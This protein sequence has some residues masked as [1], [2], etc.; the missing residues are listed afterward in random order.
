MGLFDFFKKKRTETPVTIQKFDKVCP[1]CGAGMMS[2]EQ[3]CKT[4]KK[5]V[6]DE[7]V[8]SASKVGVDTDCGRAGAKAIYSVPT[9][10]VTKKGSYVR[11]GLRYTTVEHRDS[12][13]GCWTA[14][15]VEYN[16][17]NAFYAFLNKYTSISKPEFMRECDYPHMM[18]RGVGVNEV[19]KLHEELSRRGFYVDAPAS[20]T[21]STYKVG[22]IK[23]VAS[24]LNL[25]VKGK[26]EQLIEQIVTQ[27]NEYELK[28]ILGSKVQTIS[29]YGYQWMK[30]HKEEY[31]YYNS[32]REWKSFEAYKAF[33]ETHDP[34][35]KGIKDCMDKI[36][37]DK[38]QYGRYTYDSLI[39]YYEKQG[40]KE[41][42]ILICYLKELMLDMSGALDY[43]NWKFC[44][45]EADMIPH[46]V[47]TPF[48][49]RT[50]PGYIDYY[51]PSMI[52]E[53]YELN[54]PIKLCTKEMFKD[55]AEMAIEGTL[56][57]DTEKQ[58]QE[59]LKK[60]ALA[61]ASTKRKGSR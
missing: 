20:Q 40:G 58:Y 18:F 41:R 27:A 10:G 37:S 11:N 53:V 23:E 61:F 1:H 56:D 34:V 8:I 44:N 59:Q 17:V 30:G 42:D 55:M 19:K 5:G 31:E 25:T 26:K 24:K 45:Y 57:S 6:N 51:D 21:L 29:E 4:C 47:F 7:K 28:N 50:L 16:E 49:L 2:Y 48:L 13:G 22:E 46:F 52:D 12:G 60:N 54:I 33:W 3:V 9:A 38:K 39:G 32:D 15:E 36:R 35:K 43:K 14:D